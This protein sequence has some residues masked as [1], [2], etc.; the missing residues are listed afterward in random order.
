MI[1]GL[2]AHYFIQQ[3]S[4]KAMVFL[5]LYQAGMNNILHER[6]NGNKAYTRMVTDG[7]SNK[8]YAPVTT[9]KAY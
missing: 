5:Q 1:D 2:T 8:S 3:G 6:A 7:G 9:E 4:E